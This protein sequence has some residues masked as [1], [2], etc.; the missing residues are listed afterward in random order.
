MHQFFFAYFSFSLY[1]SADIDVIA[2]RHDSNQMELF[3]DS[4]QK[5]PSYDFH[6]YTGPLL[7]VD[8]RE[9]IC[10]DCMELFKERASM[11]KL[12]PPPKQPPAHLINDYTMGGYIALESFYKAEAQNGGIGYN[13]PFHLIEKL[14]KVP[15]TCGNYH[16]TV[17][18]HIIKTFGDKFIKGKNGVVVGSQSPWAEAALLD[19]GAAHITTIEYMNITT[20]HPSL[21][22]MRPEEAAQ[23]YLNNKWEPVDFIFSYSSIEHDG[24]GRYGDPLNPFGDLEAVAKMHC[25]L[26]PGGILFLGFA[27][28]PDQLEWN[29]HR[30]YGAVRLRPLLSFWKFLYFS[31]HFTSF[32][33]V[34]QKL[35]YGKQ[36]IFVLEKKNPLLPGDLAVNYKLNDHK[37]PKNHLRIL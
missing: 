37:I 2:Q 22:T 36:P 26:K 10:F 21:S 4:L 1:L 12:W 19:A 11:P 20:D 18:A 29:A 15:T 28:G 16:N 32:S 34:P 27:V 24:L 13:W 31:G 23:A 14:M 9:I 30:V 33:E 17:C 6:N 7:Q 25:Q 3:L 8:D 35:H 5:F